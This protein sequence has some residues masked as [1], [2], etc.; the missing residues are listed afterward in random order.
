LPLFKNAAAAQGIFLSLPWLQNLAEH[1]L[2]ATEQLRIYS[3]HP[4]G[5]PEHAR[6]LLLMRHTANNKPWRMRVLQAH[7]NFY[8]SLFGPVAD[9]N[10]SDL[11]NDLML[12]AQTIA[13]ETP[14][15]DMVNLQPLARDTRVFDLLTEALRQNGMAV[16]PYFC[17]GNWYLNTLG[18]NYDQYLASLPGVLRSTLR[19]KGKMLDNS[20]V[21]LT[22]VHVPTQLAQGI[23]DFERV[24]RLSWKQAE[25]YPEFIAG[26]IT[27]CA[28]QGWLRLGIAYLDQRPIAAQL[29]IVADGVASIY[30]L[31]YDEEFADWSVGTVLTGFMMQHAIDVDRVREVDYLTGDEAYKRDWMSDRRERHGILACNLRSV[32][33]WIG[34]ARHI[35]A[36][37]LRNR[38]H[39]LRSSRSLRRP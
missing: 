18:R 35:A 8:T 16:Q 12:L 38:W 27:T 24:Y 28:E 4:Q 14:R 3:V 13:R 1:A 21:R 20:G 7:A 29:W 22:L 17:F 32:R 31:A 33:G 37:R 10:R 39:A 5:K 15:W 11:G 9:V 34:A 6:L 23:A 2:D 30:K 26:L 25:P 36:V 19:R